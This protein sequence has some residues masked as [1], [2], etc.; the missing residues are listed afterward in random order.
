MS[1]WYFFLPK[2]GLYWQ[3]L[4]FLSFSLAKF[5]IFELFLAFF[6]E[7]WIFWPH[8]LI[9]AL[10]THYF[11]RLW[12]TPPLAREMWRHEVTKRKHLLNKFCRDCSLRHVNNKLISHVTYYACAYK[13]SINLVSSWSKTWYLYG[14]I[15]R[16]LQTSP[17]SFD[18]FPFTWL[19]DLLG[20]FLRTHTHLNLVG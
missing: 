17:A 9:C 11:V 15:T 18:F 12:L 13:I 1:F 8:P 7:I 14:W 3:N 19:N 6:Y 20:L 4:N 10:M 2:I 16:S 5:E